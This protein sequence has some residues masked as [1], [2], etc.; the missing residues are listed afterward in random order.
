[1]TGNVKKPYSIGDTVKIKDGFNYIG[2]VCKITEVF[3][4]SPICY[5]TDICNSWWTHSQLEHIC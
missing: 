4:G 3:N 1:M 2:E 5:K